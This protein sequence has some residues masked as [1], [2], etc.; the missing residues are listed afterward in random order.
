ML[1][2][3]RH[4]NQVSYLFLLAVLAAGLWL[5]VTPVTIVSQSSVT[6]KLEKIVTVSH[7]R[8]MPGKFARRWDINV[9]IPPNFSSP[10]RASEGAE[11]EA[12]AEASPPSFS[13]KHS[14]A[15]YFV[16]HL[17]QSENACRRVTNK[18]RVQHVR[19]RRLS[20]CAH[21]QEGHLAPRTC[22]M[23]LVILCAY[24]TIM[25]N[26]QKVVSFTTVRLVVIALIIGM[27][28]PAEA[29]DGRPP[30][31]SNSFNPLNL[32]TAA[33]ATAA[34]AVSARNSLPRARKGKGGEEVLTLDL[35][36]Y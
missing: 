29:S 28:T 36:S 14:V 26:I 25:K 32:L 15:N 2:K 1:K 6:R 7:S 30:M 23:I 4:F 5:F 22:G 16:T 13:G 8:T 12:S 18:S 3:C 31:M 20:R 9:T 21:E 24:L 33:A 27:V 17:L 34:L 19:E 11:S 10:E 35:Q